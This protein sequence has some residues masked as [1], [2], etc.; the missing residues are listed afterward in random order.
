MPIKILF[1]ENLGYAVLKLRYRDPVH[2]SDGTPAIIVPASKLFHI[3]PDTG[4]LAP[5]LRADY[6][7]D[8]RGVE[9]AADL[10]MNPRAP[11]LVA[12]MESPKVLPTGEKGALLG[13]D[14]WCRLLRDPSDPSAPFLWDGENVVKAD[15]T[16]AEDGCPLNDYFSARFEGLIKFPRPGSWSLSLR[17]KDGASFYLEVPNGK[18]SLDR[19]AP[20]L[21]LGRDAAGHGWGWSPTAEAH[22][23]LDQAD[24]DAA[25]MPGL[26]RFRLDYFLNSGGTEI[27]LRWGVDGDNMAM[28]PVPKTAFFLEGDAPAPPE[29]GESSAGGAP[30]LVFC[31]AVPFPEAVGDGR[32]DPENNVAACYDG[33]DCCESTCIP[34]RDYECGTVRGESSSSMPWFH[35]VGPSEAGLDVEF[36]NLPRGSSWGPLS[37]PFDS[38]PI[39]T[40]NAPT[41]N[42][43][44]STQPMSMAPPDQNADG[45]DVIGPN[46]EGWKPPPPPLPPLDPLGLIADPSTGEWT[47]FAARFTGFLRTFNAGW[48]VFHLASD[49][50]STLHVDDRLVVSNDGTHSTE[51][52]SG[53]VWLEEGFHS[54]HVEFYNLAGPYSLVMQLEGPPSL[55]SAHMQPVP[56][57]LLFNSDPCRDELLSEAQEMSERTSSPL[58]SGHGRCEVVCPFEHG[59]CSGRVCRCNEDW[60]GDACEQ[61]VGSEMGLLI[62]ALACA[63][64]LAAGSATYRKRREIRTWLLWR[65]TD[66]QARDRRNEM[67]PRDEEGEGVGRGISLDTGAM[68]HPAPVAEAV[69]VPVGDKEPVMSTSV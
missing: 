62:V 36:F 32:C 54:V 13:G 10:W 56:P 33:G 5:G 29:H 59:A 69:G 16:G 50:G 27:D 65:L 19:G 18:S 52:Q 35:C 9:D 55:P 24:F 26:F 14:E 53:R 30:A 2:M 34:G 20:L 11:F 48:H 39:L 43:P 68:T 60:T 21:A 45:P 46:G 22:L 51:E 37:N 8:C 25:E 7:R 17:A 42:F 67:I 4:E 3:D 64:V 38:E 57:S 49:D 28:Q 44:V 66:S 40:A 12:Q 6:F 63:F 23:V 58:C 1:F 47:Y 31:S 15:G 61:A 41:I